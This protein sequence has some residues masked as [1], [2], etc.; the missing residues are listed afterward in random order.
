MR[1]MLVAMKVDFAC[2]ALLEWFTT[3]LFGDYTT[4]VLVRGEFDVCFEEYTKQ[5]IIQ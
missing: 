3:T 4:P 5:K 1:K 2:V